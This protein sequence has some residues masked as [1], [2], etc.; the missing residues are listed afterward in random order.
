VAVRKIIRIDEDK[1]DGC[2]DCVGS[3]A[4]GAIA[5]IN[6]KARLVSETY[7]DG[8]GACLNECPQGAIT[9]EE[10]DAPEYNE[11]AV[12]VHLAKEKLARHAMPMHPPTGCPGSAMRQFNATPVAT[13]ATSV[14]AISQLTTW[15]VQL[16]LVSPGAPFLRGADLLVCADCVPFAVSNFH[17][18]Y[19]AGKVVLVGCPKLD[20][21]QSYYDKLKAIFA[22][23]QPK[24]I[25]VAKMEVPCCNGIAQAT[26]QARNEVTPSI[27]FETITIGIRG[28]EINRTNSGQQM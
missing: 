19:L 11:A 23:N 16:K 4:E 26:L 21:L 9:I 6:G 13:E 12:T 7:C 14:D 5:V 28:D 8:L 10:R 3:C 2:G 22:T 1:C 15:P 24:S 25:T 18:K 27:P 20:D 17:E